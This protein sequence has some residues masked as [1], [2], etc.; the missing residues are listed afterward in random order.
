MRTTI[1]LGIIFLTFSDI[2]ALS[3]SYQLF[4]PKYRKVANLHAVANQKKAYTPKWK[5]LRTLN[6]ELA[7]EVGIGI[8]PPISPKDI[9]PV[10]TIP[11]IFLN[12]N[13]SVTTMAMPNQ[14]LSAV[15]AQTGQFIRYGCKKGQCGTCQAMAD[16]KWIRP[17][18]SRV[19]NL[20]AGEEYVVK[21]KETKV[22]AKSSGTFFSIRS[23]F[24][25]FYNNILGMLG[26]VKQRRV[27]RRN[28]L[29][30]IELEK[31]ILDLAAQKR[32]HRSKG[33][34]SN[35]KNMRP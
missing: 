22:V 15:A 32:K 19:P 5:K 34:S 13:S 20:A 16:G 10:G 24:M 27:A 25:G 7:D 31:N 6:D 23:F 35:E 3:N 9:G 14:P 1:N 30:R 2:V 17:C 21:L 26:F 29:E 11:V 4:S 12:G 18:V 8:S 33:G 28:Y